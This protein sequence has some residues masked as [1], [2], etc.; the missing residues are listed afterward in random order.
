MIVAFGVILIGGHFFLLVGLAHS[1]SWI[2]PFLGL[3]VFMGLS[4]LSGLFILRLQTMLEMFFIRRY[5]KRNP[6]SGWNVLI[7]GDKAKKPAPQPRQQGAATAGIGGMLANVAWFWGADVRDVMPKGLAKKA[8]KVGRNL[9]AKVAP[10]QDALA[11]RLS[12]L[13]AMGLSRLAR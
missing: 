3:P 10:V 12:G 13:R 8:T 9:T 6:N 2:N 11:A 1:M 7:K 4:V 5:L